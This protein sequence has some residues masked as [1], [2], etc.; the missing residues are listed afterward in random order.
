[1]DGRW[2]M[3]GSMGG[4]KVENANFAR[5]LNKRASIIASTLRSR[6]NEYKAK[7]VKAMADDCMEDF[8]KG[9]LKPVIDKVFK[10]SEV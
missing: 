8:G 3:Y 9:R 2:I 6:S 1:M 7:L 10:M 5:I 4:V